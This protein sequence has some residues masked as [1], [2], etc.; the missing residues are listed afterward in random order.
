[1][2]IDPDI[3]S[4]KVLPMGF[5]KDTP[6]TIISMIKYSTLYINSCLILT[7]LQGRSSIYYP[8]TDEETDPLKK[9]NNLTKFMQF[10]EWQSQ[11]IN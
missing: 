4:V 2:G 6:Y 11:E 3:L 10:I 1:M 7:A 9:V 8:F 5:L